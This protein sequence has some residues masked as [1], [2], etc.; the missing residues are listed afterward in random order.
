MERV[1]TVEKLDIVLVSAERR[2]LESPLQ[3]HKYHIR[4]GDKPTKLTSV[5]QVISTLL[6]AKCGIKRMTRINMAK[7]T[8]MCATPPHQ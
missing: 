6:L 7:G 3:P 5:L 2:P 8:V 1:T 4:P